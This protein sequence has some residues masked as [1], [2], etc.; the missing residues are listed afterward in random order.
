MHYL[1]D[2]ALLQAY[3]DRYD[4]QKNFSCNLAEAATLARYD[5]DEMISRAGELG[6]TFLILVDGECMA[7]DLTAGNKIHCERLYRG[8]NFLGF[9]AVLWDQ[10]VLNNI[11]AVT[12]CT[13]LCISAKTHRE[14]LLNDVKFLRFGVRW[15]A[16]HI[17]R[18]AV[19]FEPLK[20]RLAALI[21]QEERDG[22]FCSN[23]TI[24]AE[25]LEVSYRHLLRTLSSFCD[26]G[27]LQ[28]RKKGD[29]RILDRKYLQDLSTDAM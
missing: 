29:Y 28:K 5:T 1:N 21:L 20:N 8:V 7:Y 18:N 11:R 9:I 4:L 14:L 2:P 3:I 16:E 6:S 23:L 25:R 17:R 24:C 13:F 10:P 22:V 27:V 19:H 15:L 26:A 12:P